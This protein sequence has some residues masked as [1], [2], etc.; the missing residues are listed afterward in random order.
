MAGVDMGEADVD[1][2]FGPEDLA[3]AHDHAH[4]NAQGEAARRPLG[5]VQPRPVAIIQRE[6]RALC[7]L[8]P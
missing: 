7:R 3:R 5:A 8:S 6:P 1:Q 2:P 4:D